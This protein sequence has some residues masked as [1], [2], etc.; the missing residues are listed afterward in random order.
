MA[1]LTPTK[2]TD[3]EDSGLLGLDEALKQ[4]VFGSYGDNSLYRMARACLLAAVPKSA[5][6]EAKQS[7][8]IVI[9]DV[10][11][12]DWLVPVAMAAR[13]IWQGS[14]VRTCGSGRAGKLTQMLELLPRHLNGHGVVLIS[15]STEQVVPKEFIDATI[16]RFRVSEPSKSLF[17]KVAGTL[18]SGDVKRALGRLKID[19]ISLTALCTCLVTGD[20]AGNAA[21]KLTRVINGMSTGPVDDKVPLLDEA[22]GYGPAAEWA[23]ALKLDLQYFRDGRLDWDQVANAAILFGPPGTGKSMFAKIAAQ[24]CGL[25]IVTTSVSD[26]FMGDGYLNSVLKRQRESF[27]R[28]IELSPAFLFIDE[29]DALPSRNAHSNNDDFWRPVINDFLLQLDSVLSGKHAV[30]VLAATNRIM[31]I[32]PAILRSRRLGT[33]LHVPPPNAQ[34]LVGIFRYH[35]RTDLPDADL[36]TL[37][38][39]AVGSTGADVATWVASARRSARTASRS[40]T[41]SDL[42]RQVLGRDERSE[43]SLYRTAAHEAGHAVA[44]VVCGVRLESVSIV[45][46]DAAGGHTLMQTPPGIMDLNEAEK[47]VVTILAGRAAEAVLLGEPSTG[48]GGSAT[49]D[50]ALAT[51]WIHSLHSSYGLKDSLIWL[52]APGD[53]TGHSISDPTL[54]ASVEA[55]LRRLYGL[56]VG[57][58]MTHRDAVARVVEVL[59]AEKVIEGTC[60]A[61]ILATPRLDG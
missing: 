33:L 14:S 32:D 36:I 54:K 56:A 2:D 19:G 41:Q 38:R 43:T 1:E 5:M 59:M 31:D 50:L 40:M 35:L 25:P 8:S 47:F 53:S 22:H 61:E 37:S 42:E 26:F 17:L 30:V 23:R 4:N 28:A 27:R 16:H 20:T 55:D 29:I 12:E 15:D 24:H 21:L 52:S 34:A 45:R 44:A 49:S 18:L 60:V 6:S 11:A 48:A 58:V 13:A 46:R 3:P 51:Q 7:R 39:L 9:V 10:P 57:I